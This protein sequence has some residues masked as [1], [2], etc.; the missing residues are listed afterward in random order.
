MISKMTLL[1]LIQWPIQP[2]IS[3]LQNVLTV[4]GSAENC[5]VHLEVGRLTLFPSLI[6][7]EQALTTLTVM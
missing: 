3:L 4:Y 1:D 2:N 6:C 5:E 7:S